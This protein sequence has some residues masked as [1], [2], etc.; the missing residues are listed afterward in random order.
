MGKIRDKWKAV[1][2]A[3]PKD[4]EAKLPKGDFGPALDTFE[5]LSNKIARDLAATLKDLEQWEMQWKFLHQDMLPGLI[6]PLPKEKDYQAGLADVMRLLRGY[7]AK[8]HGEWKKVLGAK[9]GT[10]K[11]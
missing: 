11:F 7:G 8:T 5:D 1:K 3:L 6:N 9:I 4:K 10:Y 2:G